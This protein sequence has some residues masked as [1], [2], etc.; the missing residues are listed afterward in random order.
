[1]PGSQTRVGE[2][3]AALP[4]RFAIG[5]APARLHR[6]TKIGR[7]VLREDRRSYFGHLLYYLAIAL[8]FTGCRFHEWAQ[9]FLIT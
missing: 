1:M 8:F 7:N 5:P 6:T 4:Y 9:L 3:R 2:D